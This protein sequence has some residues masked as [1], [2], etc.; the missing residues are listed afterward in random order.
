MTL[1]WQGDII[2]WNVRNKIEILWHFRSWQTNMLGKIYV[3]MQKTQTWGGELAAFLWEVR[4]DWVSVSTASV[5]QASPAW[6][7]SRLCRRSRRRAPSWRDTLTTPPSRA[8]TRAASHT[9][10]SGT[11]TRT[12]TS[13][14]LVASTEGLCWVRGGSRLRSRR[15]TELCRCLL[16]ESPGWRL[17]C[18]QVLGLDGPPGALPLPGLPDWPPGGLQQLWAGD[19]SPVWAGQLPDSRQ[20][21]HPRAPGQPDRQHS[22]WGQGQPGRVLPTP[23]HSG[24]LRGHLCGGE[25][26]QDQ[27]RRPGTVCQDGWHINTK[28]RDTKTVITDIEPGTIISFYNGVKVRSEGDWEK[29]TPYK[30]LLDENND[31][32]IINVISNWTVWQNT[33][34]IPDSMTS[35]QSY[36]AT[37]G[38]KVTS[39]AQWAGRVGT[40]MWGTITKF[41]PV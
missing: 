41:N 25:A 16:E 9:A 32:V 23:A 24:R 34:D 19:G 10:T 26:E 36:S 31:I 40:V 37:L 22:E 12:E 30:M 29:P 33:Q 5:R 13:S 11:S 8:T 15:L 17:S 27:R 3:L 1:Y 20:Q 35:L 2:W 6:R 21:Q 38:H 4:G 7:S 39:G 18:L 28:S 14:S